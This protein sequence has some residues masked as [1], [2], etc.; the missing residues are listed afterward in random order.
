MSDATSLQQHYVPHHNPQ[1]EMLGGGG[2][3]EGEK[4]PERTRRGLF[5]YPGLVSTL[6]EPLQRE[7]RSMVATLGFLFREQ[8]RVPRGSHF[9]PPAPNHIAA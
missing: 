7:D 3:E 4:E 5:K 6:R 9:F 1:C 2:L 8:F